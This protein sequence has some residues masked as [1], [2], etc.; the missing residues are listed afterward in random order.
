MLHV[1][2]RNRLCPGE[3]A[4]DISRVGVRGSESEKIVSSWKRIGEH[5]FWGGGE[6][7]LEAD[8]I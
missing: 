2:S 1:G 6:T 4:R 3:R 5:F 8:S 7:L